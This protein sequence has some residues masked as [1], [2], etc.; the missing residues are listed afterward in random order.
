MHVLAMGSERTRSDRERER[1]TVWERE[2]YGRVFFKENVKYI[3]GDD[4]LKI[5][6][7]WS[8]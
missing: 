8:V 7:E 5:E 1:E 2:S 4:K 3:E 6:E